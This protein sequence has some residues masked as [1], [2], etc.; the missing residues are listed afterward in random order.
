MNDG[1]KAYEIRRKSTGEVIAKGDIESC[2]WKLH[3][4][5]STIESAVKSQN[6]KW[7]QVKCIGKVQT[8]YTVCDDA[9]GLLASG[10]LKEVAR[11]MGVNENTVRRW[12][13][14]GRAGRRDISVKA[15]QAIVPL[16]EAVQDGT[17][18]QS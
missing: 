13:E 3:V 12:A 1:S 2:A 18:S 6:H 15:R 9:A 5:R 11:E 8:I 16:E 10:T 14:K 4:S 17:H 7:M